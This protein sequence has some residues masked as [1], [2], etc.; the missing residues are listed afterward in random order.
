[1]AYI[2]YTYPD[3]IILR[4]VQSIDEVVNVYCPDEYEKKV[5][6]CPNY[7]SQTQK[8][9]IQEVDGQVNVLIV[10]KP[11]DIIIVDGE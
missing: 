1:M 4:V 3:Y 5:I 10:D 11:N 8:L 6:E 7:D 9:K 2:V